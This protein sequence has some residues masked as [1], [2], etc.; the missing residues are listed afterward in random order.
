[1]GGDDQGTWP[2][3]GI[4]IN[5]C[6]RSRA[7]RKGNRNIPNIVINNATMTTCLRGI[8]IGAEVGLLDWWTGGG[9]GIGGAMAIGSRPNAA[10]DVRR[11]HL[12]SI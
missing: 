2:V 8:G 7:L 4:N 1:M 11:L 5:K 12:A 9:N 6:C 3:P 10:I